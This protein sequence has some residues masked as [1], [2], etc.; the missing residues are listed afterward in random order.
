[1]S[2]Y[3]VVEGFTLELTPPS[4]SEVTMLIT[5][6]T[7]E[8]SKIVRKGVYCTPLKL[9]LST[10]TGGSITDGNGTASV[11]I[12]TSATKVKADG[13]LVMLEGD[14]VSAEFKGTASGRPAVQLVQVTIKEAGQSKVKGV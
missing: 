4:S 8:H 13:T 1:M 6:D 9:T 10:Y 2:K 7:A 5:S 3:I 12:N 11:T 14:S